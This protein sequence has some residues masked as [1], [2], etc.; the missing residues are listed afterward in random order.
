MA[1]PEQLPD[2][3]QEA[4]PTPGPLSTVEPLTATEVEI[5]GVRFQIRKLLPMEAFAVIEAFRPAFKEAVA[6]GLGDTTD[7]M[8]K[9]IALL[10][11]LPPERVDGLRR[12]L[13]KQIIFR[14]PNAG[15]PQVLGGNEELAFKDLDVVHIYELIVRAF[16]VNFSGSWAALSSRFPALKMVSRL[17]LRETLTPSSPT[18]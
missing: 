16:A 4:E 3:E 18:Q 6:A 13:F 17:R 12:A 9:G 8:A 14:A 11:G 15:T 2:V 7:D 5:E 10:G 1:E